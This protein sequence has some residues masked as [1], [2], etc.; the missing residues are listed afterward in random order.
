[1]EPCRQECNVI[2][3]RR[4]AKQAF[5]VLSSLNPV[6]QAL[7]RA[8][9]CPCGLDSAHCHSDNV[10]EVANRSRPRFGINGESIEATV[11]CAATLHRYGLTYDY[12]E[13][14]PKTLPEM[15]V[16]VLQSSSI[17][18][19]NKGFANGSYIRMGVPVR[20]M[21]GGQEETS[22]PR[23]GKA[24][25]ERYGPDQPQP[26]WICFPVLKCSNRAPSSPQGQFPSR[27]HFG[28]GKGGSHNG[29][30]N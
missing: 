13:L 11:F 7:M 25:I 23:G 27:R 22:S 2:K 18:P 26:R 5:S 4:H 21:R 12:A 24:G 30:S 9:T 28:L 19:G 10:R 3:Q 15:Y 1:M 20:E 17:K 14:D 6:K 8:S 16:L 29:L